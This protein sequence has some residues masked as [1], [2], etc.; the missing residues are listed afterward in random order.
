MAVSL[1]ESLPEAQHTESSSTSG[2]SRT[3][4]SALVAPAKSDPKTELSKIA[5]PQN[6]DEWGM[7]QK[8][9]WRG[10]PRLA[11][12]WIRIWSKSQDSVY[13]LRTSDMKTTFDIDEVQ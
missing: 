8:T 10:H 13:Y 5:W 11:A 3:V 1:V 7:K 6:I 9:I 4:T 12:G 2:A